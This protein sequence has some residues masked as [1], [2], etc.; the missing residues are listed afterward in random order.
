MQNSLAV[1]RGQLRNRPVGGDR[2]GLHQGQAPRCPRECAKKLRPEVQALRLE[3]SE[4]ALRPSTR[5]YPLSC[6]LGREKGDFREGIEGHER[7]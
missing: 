7:G 6:R 1:H 5:G 2:K 3:R 4:T